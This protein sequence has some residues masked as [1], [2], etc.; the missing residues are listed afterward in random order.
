MYSFQIYRREDDLGVE[1]STGCFYL[2]FY[3]FSAFFSE[4]L[5]KIPKNG[6]TFMCESVDK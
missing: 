2:V 6:F 3:L 1:F 4:R 5:S